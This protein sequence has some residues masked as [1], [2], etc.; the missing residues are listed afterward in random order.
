MPKICKTPKG[1]PF[2]S[3]ILL[4]ISLACDLEIQ[5]FDKICEKPKGPAFEIM[6]QIFWACELEIHIVLKFYIGV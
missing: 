3:E 6:R 5:D 2:G 4:Q 1:P